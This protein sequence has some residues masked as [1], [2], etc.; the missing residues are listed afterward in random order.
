MLGSL[1]EKPEDVKKKIALFIAGVCSVIIFAVWLRFTIKDAQAV[2]AETEDKSSVFFS[3]IKE[4]TSS[5]YKDISGQFGNI[6]EQFSDIKK[7]QE[8]QVLVPVSNQ[9]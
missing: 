3:R 5:L 7:Y 8:A 6:K 9:E 1:K 2:L 4:S